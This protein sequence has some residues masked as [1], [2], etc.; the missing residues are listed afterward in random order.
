MSQAILFYYDVVCPYAFLA[1]AQIA[2]RT[3]LEIEWVPVLLG[4]I[5]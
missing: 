1:A 4:G 5:L 2:R 3:D